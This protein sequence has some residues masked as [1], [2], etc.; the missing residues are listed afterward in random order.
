[1]I[2]ADAS[3]IAVAGGAIIG[4][5]LALGRMLWHLL[6]RV[7][8]LLDEVEGTPAE[9]GIPRRAGVLERLGEF[10]A[11]REQIMSELSALREN[12]TVLTNT[13]EAIRADTK[14]LQHNGGSHVA[15]Y[16]RDTRDAVQQL[17]D[18]VGTLVRRMD[19]QDQM[20]EMAADDAHE[21]RAQAANA[22]QVMSEVQA[23]L[24]A[25]LTDAQ[26]S[27]HTLL[28]EV[29]ADLLSDRGRGAPQTE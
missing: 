7:T 12:Q 20:I 16:T 6:R 4:G 23:G 15:D 13:M 5:G 11:G 14:Q 22:H 27:L 29:R 2:V 19:T 24:D 28:Q 8:R 3:A 26:E 1:M 21:A 17:A 18:Q 10:E 25:H 9:H